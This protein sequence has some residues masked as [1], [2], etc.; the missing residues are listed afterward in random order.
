ML[1]VVID[2]NVLV[3]RYLS[4]TGSPAQIFTFWQ[5][6]RFTLLVSEPI[7]D[8]YKRALQ[9]PHV[10]GKHQLTE[11]QIVELVNDLADIATIVVAKK[12]ITVITA[13]PDDNK[14]LECAVE[15]G[16][17]YIVSGNKHLLDLKQ[18]L[19]IRILAPSEFLVALE[20]E[21]ATR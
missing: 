3:S 17:D 18:Y 1:R 15:G 16:A 14:F 5:D 9:Y 19:E 6:K 12:S 7:L 13:D 4:P 10:Q 11:A 20:Y 21:Q 2:T 8:E